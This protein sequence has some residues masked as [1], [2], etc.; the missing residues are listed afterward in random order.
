LD[1]NH[2]ELVTASLLYRHLSRTRASWDTK[3][4]AFGD[5][6]A[7]LAV[8]QKGRSSV[9]RML[10][11]ARKVAAVSIILGVSLVWGYIQSEVNPADAPSRGLEAPG[12]HPDTAAKGFGSLLGGW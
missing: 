2:G 3:S 12:V 9:P 8:L 1:S 4:L 11:V 7:A 5:N 6:L 10:A